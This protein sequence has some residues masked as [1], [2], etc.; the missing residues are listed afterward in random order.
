MK[1]T[2]DE[3]QRFLGDYMRLIK[4]A[5]WKLDARVGDIQPCSTCSMRSSCQPELFADDEAI[6]GKSESGDVCLDG[7][8]WDR[9]KVAFLKE[10]EAALMAEH[11]GLKRV[12][13][14]YLYERDK[15]KL[16]VMGEDV[17]ESYCFEKVKKS[18]HGAQP[19]LV[20]H[21]SNAGKVI[22]IKDKKNGS[23]GGGG[24][25]QPKKT[26]AEKRK[27][28]QERRTKRAVGLVRDAILDQAKVALKGGQT[29]LGFP[30]ALRATAVFGISGDSSR[31]EHWKEIDLWKR[32]HGTDT[33]GA[34]LKLTAKVLER[35]EKLIADCEACDAMQVYKPEALHVCELLGWDFKA[36]LDAAT[37][38]M[39]EPKAW[40]K[41]AEEE[42]KAAKI[43]KDQVKP[44]KT[45]SRKLAGYDG[46]AAA[47]GERLY[48]D[49]EEEGPE[50]E[51]GIDDD[52]PELEEE[53]FGEDEDELEDEE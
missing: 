49:E 20:V 29:D 2:L 15:S 32:L 31:D 28:L 52:N 36:Y 45:R 21:G 18:D 26:L 19:A 34:E 51:D 11:K 50:G 17:I 14:E 10:R 6:G 38:E 30:V 1:W 37:A 27:Q 40:A 13:T 53:N 7:T 24:G 41:E 48:S 47:A 9:K 42:A 4:G 39:P 23:H 46:K 16:G 33:H 44:K 22:Y 12:A 5:P 43:G 8:C 25:G 35:L 3:L